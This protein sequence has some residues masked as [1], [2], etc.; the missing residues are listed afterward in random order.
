MKVFVGK[1]FHSE[2]PDHKPATLHQTQSKLVGINISNDKDGLVVVEGVYLPALRFEKQGDL[3]FIDLS[4]DEP[5]ATLTLMPGPPFVHFNTVKDK[6][7]I[8]EE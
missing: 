5:I 3:V 2:L 7:N 8:E 4:D 1:L 6:H